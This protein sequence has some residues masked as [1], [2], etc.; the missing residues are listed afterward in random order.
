MMD[1]EKERRYK[2]AL[3]AA[4]E[5]ILRLHE[6]L[7]SARQNS[8]ASREPIAVIGM[9]CLFPGVYPRDAETPEDFYRALLEGTDSVVDVPPERLRQWRSPLP[10]RE[11]P[12]TPGVQRAALLGRDPYTFDAAFFEIPPAE[13]VVTDPH[14][15]L[16]LELVQQALWDAGLPK[17]AEPGSDTGVFCGKSG[18]DYLFD[19]L[20]AGREF[21][22]N[23]YTLT[24]NMH[25]SLAGR[26][27]YF[28]DWHGPSVFYETACSTALVAVLN[29][30]QHLRRG[31]CGL[32]VAGAV[33]LLMGP[34]ASHWLNAMHALAPDGCCKAFGAGADGFGRGEGGG[35]LVLQPYSDAVRAGNRIHALILGGAAGA[36]GRSRNFAAPSAE[37]QR[38]V[39][40]RALQ[41]AGIAPD[42]VAFV[43]THGTG[44]PIGDPIEAES[45]AAVY[46]SRAQKPLR[47][48]SVKSNV[49]HL[50]AAAGMAALVKCILSV[51]EGKI[52]KTLHAA[53][54]NPLLDLPG[55]GL[56]LCRESA[57]W[58]EGYRRRIAGVSGFAISGSLAHL[59]VAEAPPPDELANAAG[60]GT[61]PAASPAPVLP[62]EVRMLPLSARGEKELEMQTQAALAHLENGGSFAQLCDVAANARP[63]DVRFP[64]R[65]AVCA[66]TAEAPEI[67]RNVLNHKKQRAALRGRYAGT[68]PAVIFLYSG[69]GS[70]VPGMGRH[71]YRLFPEFRAVMDRC[72]AIAAPRLGHSLLEALFSGSEDLLLQTRVTQ[73]AIYSHQ[74]ALTALL[75]SRGVTPQ[76]VT[77]HSVGEY[78]AAQA[79]GIVSLEDGL[80]IVLQRGELAQSIDTPGAMAAVLGEE[81]CVQELLCD[82][83]LQVSIAA[84]NGRDTVTLAGAASDLQLALQHL[85]AAGMESRPM[86][87]SHAFHCPL[88]EPVLPE[89]QAFVRGKSLKRPTLPFLSSA[90][91][92]YAEDQDWAD[93]FVHQ[94]RAPVQFLRTVEAAKENIFL[95]IGA[96][97]SLS[98]FGRQIR[99]QD[100]WLFAQ[101]G[102][103]PDSASQERP[104]AL[105]LARLFSLGLTLDH[106]WLVA[107]PWQPEKAPLP[108]FQRDRFAPH[109]AARSVASVAQTGTGAT[110]KSAEW[111]AGVVD[112]PLYTLME[113]QA[114]A[115]DRLRTEQAAFLDGRAAVVQRLSDE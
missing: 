25:S 37:G 9:S 79:A 52:P 24:G 50:E 55:L 41:D 23:P 26:I 1:A 76:A 43:E 82:L 62:L 102:D 32:A 64:E 35:A 91:A 53:S 86:P 74:A 97:P 71:L 6:E 34:T 38:Q 22:D 33:N 114:R 85:L 113:A 99:P 88:I 54:E 61:R 68:S 75:A 57:A 4:K 15:R 47:I 95:E 19:I 98:G 83:K 107:S 13:A 49:A 44:T 40:R 14:H 5:N 12:Q 67:L 20:G 42:E 29:A 105:T 115:F 73:P 3:Q 80:E 39:I 8:A 10:E 31:D 16:F 2:T 77:G 106:R 110:G 59:L 7:A 65:L 87:V 72:E 92:A 94:T 58:P 30:V 93:Y 48:G 100:Q 27:S 69:Q 63:H 112:S 84:V 109:E 104:L 17:G 101:N 18:N 70:Q 103:G 36:D 96:G 28:F 60:A 46:G 78:A 89:F 66:T 111:H 21:V 81:A 51:R 108:S 56:K 45:L 90:L 11:R